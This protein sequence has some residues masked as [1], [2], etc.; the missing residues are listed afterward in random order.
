MHDTAIHLFKF[1]KSDSQIRG[2]IKISCEL[3]I[4]GLDQI[5]L[6]LKPRVEQDDRPL[7]FVFLL[8]YLETLALSLVEK[9][10]LIGIGN[11]TIISK[12][13][14]GLINDMYSIANTTRRL[15]LP[16]VTGVTERSLHGISASRNCGN[17]WHIRSHFLWFNR[18]GLIL[19]KSMLTQIEEIISGSNI[20]PTSKMVAMQNYLKND[21]ERKSRAIECE[22]FIGD[23]FINN[24]VVLPHTLS[25]KIVFKRNLYSFFK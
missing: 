7:E 10:A 16:A 12:E 17:D 23:I 4:G 18:S 2:K 25:R 9:D 11:D 24:G 3:H 15:E 22:K 21:W 14:G 13:Y 8:D 1:Q 6:K 5:S 20:S 19:L